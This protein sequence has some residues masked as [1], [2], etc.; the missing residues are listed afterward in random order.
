[1][2]IDYNILGQRIK[3]KRIEKKLS[4]FKVA[5]EM[6]ISVAYLSRIEKGTSQINLKRLIEI[7]NILEVSPGELLTGISAT[8]DGYL[9]KDFSEV[10]NQCNEGKQRLIY[11]IAKAVQR[12]NV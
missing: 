9:S 10:L 2:F 7:S 12:A 4:Q 8:E 11:E 5:E 1:M 3:A 6:D